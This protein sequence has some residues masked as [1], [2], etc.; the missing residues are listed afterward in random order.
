MRKL[1]K[2]TFGDAQQ[3]AAIT[4]K[5]TPHARKT[6]FAEVMEDGTL[7]IRVAAPAEE[8]KA[9]TALIEFLAES[10][11]IPTSHIEIVVGLASEKKLISLIGV[12]PAGVEAVVEQWQQAA[13]KPKAAESKAKK[14]PAPKKKK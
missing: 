3:G 14:S 10:M 7:K 4:V 12:S 9:N 5:V 13:A 1:D 6:E 8:G 2:P 11:N